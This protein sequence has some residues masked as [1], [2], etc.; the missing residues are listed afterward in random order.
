MINSRSNKDHTDKSTK[1][2]ALGTLFFKESFDQA[3][4]KKKNLIRI[5]KYLRKINF[6]SKP[7]R[8]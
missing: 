4:N 1:K 2:E 6:C 7:G 3:A 5:D 8:N